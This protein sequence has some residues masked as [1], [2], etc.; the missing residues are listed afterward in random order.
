MRYIAWLAMLLPLSVFSEERIL[1]YHSD[2]LVRADARIEV[3]ETITVRSENKQIRRGIYRD[4]PTRYKDRFGNRAVVDYQ[5]L[6]VLRDGRPEPHHFEER[7]NGVR[8]YFGSADVTLEPGVYSYTYRYDA[9]RMLGFFENRDEFYWNVTGNGWAFPIEKATA[10]VRFDFGLDAADTGADAWTG[11]QQSR[12][13]DFDVT[14]RSGEVRFATTAP[15]ARQE[16]LTILVDW[17]KGYVAEPTDWQRFI[18]LLQDN[19]E[20]LFA[21]SGLALILAYYLVVWHRY[22]RDPVPGVSFTRYEP[23]EGFS[24][25]SLRFIWKMGYDSKAFTAA[26]VNLAVK[27]RLRIDESG[28]RYSLIKTAPASSEVPLARGEQ[29][30]LDELFSDVNGLLLDSEN[31]AVLSAARQAHR[32]SLKRDY[33]QRYFRTNGGMNIPAA[34]LFVVTLVVVFSGGQPPPAVFVI[35]ALIVITLVVFAYLLKK[36]TGIGR[37][38][39]DDTEGFREYLEIAEKDEL[40]LR[41]PPEKTP[42][43]FESYLPYA[44]ALGVEQQWAERFSQLFDSLRGADGQPYQPKWFNG[45]W[46]TFNLGSQTA[47]LTSGLNSAISSS[48]TAPGSS[49]GGGGGGF[50]GGGGGGGGGGGW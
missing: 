39:L 36:P 20:L 21:L 16:G 33:R 23:P 40:N 19:R 10:T 28:G 24:P 5:P 35:I 4:Y 22:G 41:N 12:A 34:I 46:N 45:S 43:L 13:K 1:S 49:S 31:H 18:W 29:E 26:T 3:T 47:G 25:A 37:R 2:I 32:R 50:S 9:G 15:L 38:V 42:A 30:L 11:T 27:G 44:L 7:S 48:M 14:V 8:T 6:S 17:P